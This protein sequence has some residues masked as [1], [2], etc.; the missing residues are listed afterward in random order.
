[1]VH[2]LVGKTV[3]AVYLADDAQAIRF[4]TA[5]GRQIVASA[6]GDCCSRTWI[7]NVDSPENVIG[8][9]VT[10]ANDIDM[11]DRGS[12]DEYSDLQYYGFKIA[13]AKGETIIDYRNESNGYYGGNLAWPV[14][15]GEYDPFYGGVY[16]QN[17]SKE[18]WK[19]L[20]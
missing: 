8:S 16:G 19:Q 2:Q 12:P 1:M 7:E 3:V 11:P 4:D 18:K 20:A 9:P 14:E 13:T 5:D 17:V 15:K 6:D 10:E